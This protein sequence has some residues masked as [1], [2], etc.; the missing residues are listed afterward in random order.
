MLLHMNYLFI[1]TLLPFDYYAVMWGAVD[2]TKG[3]CFFLQHSEGVVR[4]ILK[5]SH[6]SK[7]SAWFQ[8]LNCK[9]M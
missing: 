2:N 6:F 5:K 3:D 7:H 9:G 8:E 4:W 1:F